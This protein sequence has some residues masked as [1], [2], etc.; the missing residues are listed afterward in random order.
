LAIAAAFLLG[1]F[2]AAANL[3]QPLPEMGDLMRWGVF[4]L[5]GGDDLTGNA[6]VKGDMG[7]AGSGDITLSGNATI[8]G[9]LYYR[10]NGMLRLNG[11]ATITGTRHHDSSS[12]S[13]LDNGVNEAINSS[14]HAASFTSSFAY[15]GLQSIM[16]S[17]HR[18]VTIVAQDDRPGNS[19]VLNLT[20][21]VLRG[22]ATFTLQGGA[23]DNFIINVSS[24][25]SLSG[26]AK[27]ILSGGVKWNDVLFNVIGGGN[28]VKLSGQSYLEG[29]LMANNRTV[30]LSGGATVK[31]E[32]VAN[33]VSLSGG[34]Q[35]I[36]PPITSP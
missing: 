28:E 21:F 24:E 6:L 36:H 26:T 19:T 9:N 15:A 35:V 23:A 11:N 13:Q 34:G 22:G 32:V 8:D 30:K 3:L 18:N 4:S 29:I 7:V 16:L 5:G 17:G 12:D 2:S 27:I 25:F 1:A 31:G 10:T 33:R 14:N 20:D